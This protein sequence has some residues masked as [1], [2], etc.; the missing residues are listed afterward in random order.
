MS[1]QGNIDDILD[2]L[3]PLE[4]MVVRSLPSKGRSG[5]VYVCGIDE[6]VFIKDVWHQI[7]HIGSSNSEPEVE[8]I[9]RPRLTNCKNC[10]AVLK[11]RTCEYCG[12]QY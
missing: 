10:G 11:G 1:I 6:W 4:F 2:K 9:E 3:C 5:V 8:R 12:T 7:G